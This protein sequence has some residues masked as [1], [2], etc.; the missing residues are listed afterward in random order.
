MTPPLRLTLDNAP[1][2]KF[3]A[4]DNVPADTVVETALKAKFPV[5]LFEIEAPETKIEAASAPTVPVLLMTPPLRLTLDNAP[6]PKL[7]ALDNV[8][9]NTVIE[10]A[11]KA[12]TPV[13]LF[14]TDPLKVIVPALNPT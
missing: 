12:K 13:E 1:E 9:A 8:P 4:L 6:E 11:L 10:P 3:P 14:E 7:P 2:P 5:E